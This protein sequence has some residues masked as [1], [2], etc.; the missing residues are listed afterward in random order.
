[1]EVPTTK[2]A[3]EE[4]AVKLMNYEVSLQQYKD[5]FSMENVTM[6]VSY[7]AV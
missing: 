6:Y 3:K 7:I 2:E 5:A 4:F 1:M